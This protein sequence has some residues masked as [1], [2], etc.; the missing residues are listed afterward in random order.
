MSEGILS[1]QEDPMKR[2]LVILGVVL[3]ADLIVLALLIPVNHSSLLPI[4]KGFALVADAALDGGPLPPPIPPPPQ[5]IGNTALDG[6]PLPPPIPPPQPPPKKLWAD[7]P[8]EALMAD[9]G[10]L[11]PPIPPPQPPPKKFRADAWERSVV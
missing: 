5:K 1:T 3:F 9:G 10:P 6:G 8:L 2:L 4:H 7:R 11:P